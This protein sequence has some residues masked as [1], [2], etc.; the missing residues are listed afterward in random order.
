MQNKSAHVLLRRHRRRATLML[1]VALVCVVFLVFV[2]HKYAVKLIVEMIRLLQGSLLLTAP[3]PR[4]LPP[5]TPVEMI[6]CSL[7]IIVHKTVAV[8]D[9]LL[10][11]HKEQHVK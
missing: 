9:S 11:A 2:K 7:N 6:E 3:L 8:P 10:P 5:K 4:T 1:I